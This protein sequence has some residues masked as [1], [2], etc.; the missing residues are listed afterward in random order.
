[1]KDSLEIINKK[2]VPEEEIISG[3]PCRSVAI[4]HT[5]EKGIRKTKQGFRERWNN[6][7]CILTCAL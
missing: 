4:M 2:C 5:K 7:S 1:M 6:I 3:S